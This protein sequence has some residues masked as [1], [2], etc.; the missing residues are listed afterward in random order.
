VRVSYDGPALDLPDRRPTN[1]EILASDDGHR[2]LA[3]FMLRRLADRVNALHRNGR[4]TL[5]FHFDH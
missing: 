2:K 5:H 1:E 4:S 3:G